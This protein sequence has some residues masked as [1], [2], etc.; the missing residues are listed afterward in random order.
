MALLAR[1]G[2]VA[3]MSLLASCI[4][5]QQQPTPPPPP[6]FFPR[7]MPPEPQQQNPPAQT[8]GAPAATAPQQPTGQPTVYG[9]LSL[10]NASLTEVIDLLA[11]QLKINYI[12]DPRVKGGVIL[13]TY[14]ETKNIDTR[15][16]LETILRINGYGMVKQ[17][18]L[19]RIV[20]LPEISHLPIP[21]ETIT[22]SSS[23]PEDDRTMLNLVFLKF[24]TADE[25]MKVLQP[26]VGEN[27]SIYTYAPANLL[28]ML[29]SRRNMRRLMDLVAMFDSDQLANQ[30][31]HVF[32]VKN[33]RPSD[34][35][36][37]LEGIVKAIAMSDKT[38]PIK[39]IP[40]DRINTIIA[41]APNPG[42]FVEVGKW[43]DKLD[44]PVRIT[45]GAVNNYVYRVR[46]GDAQSIGC[47]IQALYGQLSGY[48]AQGYGYNSMANCMPNGGFPGFGGGGGGF[49]G[50]GMYGGGMGGGMY[51]GGMYGGGGNYPGAYNNPVVATPTG[52]I[53]VQT[54]TVPAMGGAGTTPVAGPDL[55]GTYLGN[56]PLSGSGGGRVP[57][58]VA[59]PFNNTLLIQATPQEYENILSVLKDLDVPPRQVL[60]EAKIYSIDLTH[61]FSS[62]V[63]AKLQ[64]VTGKVAHT[65]LGD[66]GMGT[67][68]L[69]T[70][71][72]VGK[73]RELLAAVQLQ[74]A[75]KRAKVLS[76]PAI[77]ATDSIPA[78]ITVGIEVPTLT[79]QAVT[80]A[81][82][83]GNSL[84]ANSVSSRSTGVTLN[85]VAR[86]TPSGVVTMIIDQQVS[87][88]LPTTTSGIQ[89]PSFDDKSIK[90][91]ITVQDGDMVAIGGIIDERSTLSASGVPVLH[92]IPILGA[93]FGSRSYA[94][95]RSELVIFITPHVIYDT[96]QMADATDELKGR[97][98][99]LRKDV[100]E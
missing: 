47:S 96:H 100:K 81:Q 97:L 69:S 14:G 32:E 76:A 50:G 60:I 19:Y 67:T 1:L 59:N 92:R 20:P 31:V 15:S 43:L 4:F 2:R 93:A 7:P 40:I 18:D 83:G 30:R 90:T 85:I 39:F 34:L 89:S 72:L 23:V 87:A 64:Q 17:G 57:R 52:P 74:E 11:R 51:G 41:V 78:S 53:A 24:V 95:E 73:S 62:D 46:Y 5:A 25:L 13:N 26:F 63:Q 44:V 86:V 68:N 37:E 42:V 12:L 94:K 29:D 98:K 33:G 80:P 16:L 88:A 58:V 9:G 6:G 35:A 48:G 71:L 61:A 66:F 75:E 38:A 22:D 21:P 3:V 79:A 45:A 82:Q 56:A 49:G 36:K 84:F 54:P 70:A 55:T 28:L 77:I 91:Q 8:P 10:N 27:A 65:F 99:K